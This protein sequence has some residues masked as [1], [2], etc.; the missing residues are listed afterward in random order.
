VDRHHEAGRHRAQLKHDHDHCQSLQ[1]QESQFGLFCMSLAAQTVDALAGARFDFLLFDA[2]HTPTSLPILYSQVLTLAGSRT[3]ALVRMPSQDPAMFKAVLDM[4]VDTVMVP[5]VRDAAEARAAVAAVR[6]PPQGIRGVGGSV[7][8]TGYGRDQ[9][10]YATA[11]DRVCLLLQVESVEGLRNIEAICAV[12]GVDGI[13]FGPVDLATDLG[14]L[15]QPGHPEVVAAVLGGIR[16]ARAA[17]KAA[18]ILAGETQCRQY[19]DAGAT[20]V[21]LG[22]DLGLLVRAA[23]QLAKRWVLTEGLKES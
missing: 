17:G 22:S 16:R 8:A 18:G 14:H 9:A 19:V 2:E 13:F 15:A 5:N 10:Y 1:G 11:A 6:Y 4:G 20:M 21:C 7:R 23:D 12:D 3:Q